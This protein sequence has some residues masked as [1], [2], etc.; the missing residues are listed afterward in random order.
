MEILTLETLPLIDDGAVS[1]A[2]NR[3]LQAAY[4]DCVDR[5]GLKKKRSVAIKVTLEP[6]PNA[7]GGQLERAVLA[8]EIQSS[9]PG[10]T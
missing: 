6:E 8:V 1:I 9:C 3:A 7:H 10:K 2:V 5:P 4:H